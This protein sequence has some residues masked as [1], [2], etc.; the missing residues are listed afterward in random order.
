MITSALLFKL[1]SCATSRKQ[2]MICN[3]QKI[4][5]K[6]QVTEMRLK[7]FQKHQAFRLDFISHLIQELQGGILGK[8][9]SAEGMVKD[10]DPCSTCGF[11]Q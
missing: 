2:A 5:S 1:M 7:L 6:L 11:Q 8:V 9:A 10:V 4:S 3:K